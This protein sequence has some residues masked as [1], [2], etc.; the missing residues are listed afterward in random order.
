MK[1]RDFLNFGVLATV[2]G[3][4]ATPTLASELVKSIPASAKGKTKNIIFSW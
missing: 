4:F 3:A 1:R 2:G